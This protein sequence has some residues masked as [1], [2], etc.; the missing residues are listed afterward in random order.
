MSAILCV[1]KK[2]NDVVSIIS[3]VLSMIGLL[4]GMIVSPEAL[5]PGKVI[6]GLIWLIERVY[7][8]GGM[9]REV[10]QSYFLMIF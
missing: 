7:E 1:T 3:I 5:I 9:I 8:I 4:L 6:Y 10:L 2:R